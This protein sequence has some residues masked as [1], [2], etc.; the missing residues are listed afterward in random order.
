VFG[1]FITDKAEPNDI[2]VFLLVEDSFDV[3]QIRGEARLLFEHTAAQTYFGASVFWLRRLA[4]LTEEDAAIEDW[5]IRRDGKRRGI[6]EMIRRSECALL[7][8][9]GPA[10]S[11]SLHR[12]EVGDDLQAR[13][14]I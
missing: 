13:S 2:D 10:T 9:Q 11:A 12:E 4:V 8:C 5:Q 14:R 1:S 6:V 3:S 7:K